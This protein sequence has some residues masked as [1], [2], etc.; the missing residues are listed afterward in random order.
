MR[1]FVKMPYF[2]HFFFLTKK[3]IICY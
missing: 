1:L 2:T 3:N